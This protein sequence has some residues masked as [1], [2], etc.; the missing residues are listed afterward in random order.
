[1]WNGTLVSFK[2]VAQYSKLS[3]YK[4]S[5]GRVFP[6]ISFPPFYRAWTDL[7]S[8][9]AN[10]LKCTTRTGVLATKIKGKIQHRG[11]RMK[12]KLVE[13]HAEP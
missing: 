1:M 3:S 9:F 13:G 12:G 8:V 5:V 6:K 4:F 2:L 7:S 10:F 11:H